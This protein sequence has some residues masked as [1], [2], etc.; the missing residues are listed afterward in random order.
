M[1]TRLEEMSSYNQL[2]FTSSGINYARCSGEL[3]KTNEQQKT[4][5]VSRRWSNEIT[6]CYR[7]RAL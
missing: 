6:T 3:T 7:S 4:T 2:L 5:A 1:A